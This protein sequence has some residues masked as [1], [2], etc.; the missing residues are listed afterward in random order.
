[1]EFWKENE[2]RR[3]KKKKNEWDE[4]EGR[5]WAADA[6][7]MRT[8]EFDSCPLWNLADLHGARFIFFFFFVLLSTLSRI[9]KFHWKS[10]SLLERNKTIICPFYFFPSSEE[11]DDAQHQRDE[12]AQ[13]PTARN[14]KDPRK[15]R[16][17]KEW[18]SEDE[19]MR[20]LCVVIDAQDQRVLP[21]TS[22]TDQPSQKIKK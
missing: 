4:N 7:G 9:E 3:G 21:S 8:R 15:R 17:E 13:P 12:S 20:R 14:F 5:S 1:M 6:I 16:K 2:R 22:G 10:S 18:P 11:G 19:E